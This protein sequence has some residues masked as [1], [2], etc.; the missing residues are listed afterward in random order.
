ML[1]GFYLL[2]GAFEQ[3]LPEKHTYPRRERG[4]M[5]VNCRGGRSRSVALVA[6]FL[7]VEMP[8][9]Y[10]TLDDALAHVRARRDAARR[11]NGSRRRS[12]CWSRP[13]AGRRAGSRWSTR[14]PE[15]AV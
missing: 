7:H 2:R 8:E 11:T 1:A 6:L 12:R 5:L 13:P 15:A 9:R 10:P 14:T 3:R 4:H